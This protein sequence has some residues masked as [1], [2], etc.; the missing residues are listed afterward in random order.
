MT[1]GTPCKFVTFFNAIT[2]EKA[3]LQGKSPQIY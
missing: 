3:C 1:G 2:K